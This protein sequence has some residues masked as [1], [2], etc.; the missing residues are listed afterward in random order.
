MTTEPL[1]LAAHKA[2]MAKLLAKLAGHGWKR[3]NST[4]GPNLSKLLWYS[5]NAT[6]LI[7]QEFPDGQ[8]YE[9][10]APLDRSGSLRTETTLAAI[11]Q[12]AK[13]A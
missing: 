4:H 1:L 9:V 3:I 6:V 10:Y 12:L 13:E 8:G 7:V 5:V 2:K 11:D